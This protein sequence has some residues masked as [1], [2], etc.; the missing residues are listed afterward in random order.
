MEKEEVEVF[1]AYYKD[2]ISATEN[3]LIKLAL[4]RAI[5]S[6]RRNVKRF[7]ICTYERTA[8]AVNIN[9][10]HLKGSPAQGL[11]SYDTTT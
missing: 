9:T 8:I 3:K 2:L 10:N 5:S 11:N 4:D 6:Y 7:E 1:K